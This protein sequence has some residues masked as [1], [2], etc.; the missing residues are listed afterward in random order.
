MDVRE[1]VFKQTQ[2]GFR[3]WKTP[4][5]IVRRELRF[6]GTPQRRESSRETGKWKRY[7]DRLCAHPRG[8]ERGNSSRTGSPPPGPRSSTEQFPTRVIVSLVIKRVP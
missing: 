8:H 2:K 5:V 6:E 3:P 1:G 7:T 4:S